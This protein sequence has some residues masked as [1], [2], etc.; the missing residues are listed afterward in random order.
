[1]NIHVAGIISF[2]RDSLDCNFFRCSS[3][4]GKEPVVSRFLENVAIEDVPSAHN[5]RHRALTPRGMHTPWRMVGHDFPDPSSV[6][7]HG[8]G[9]A[10]RTTPRHIV[11]FPSALEKAPASFKGTNSNAP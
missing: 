10:A 3:S 7:C 5:A 4:N 11:T 6:H 1:M 8:N 9:T 2:V